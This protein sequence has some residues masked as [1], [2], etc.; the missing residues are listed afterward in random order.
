MA[1]ILIVDD[2]P[3][4]VESIVLVL[5]KEGHKVSGAGNVNEG[6]KAVQE[7]DPDLLILDVMMEESDDGIR[8]AQQL[9]RNEFKKPILMLTSVGRVTGMKFDKDDEMI[10]VDAFLEKPVSPAVLNN[11]VKELL[12]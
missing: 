3:D 12:G 10:P 8:M 2:D 6:F 7:V 1:N 11:K 5:E 9:R 4:I